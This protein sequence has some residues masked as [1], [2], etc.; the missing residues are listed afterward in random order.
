MADEQPNQSEDPRL[1][2]QVSSGGDKQEPN[3][4]QRREL[5]RATDPGDGGPGYNFDPDRDID[6]WM[7]IAHETKQCPQCGTYIPEGSEAYWVIENPTD[8]FYTPYCNEYHYQAHNKVGLWAEKNKLD[9]A[10]LSL[11]E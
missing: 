11:G 5:T 8:G 1:D 2:T 9:P 3:P 4:R 10:P 7:P 6:F